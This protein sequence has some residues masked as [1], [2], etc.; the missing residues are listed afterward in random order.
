MKRR[1]RSTNLAY[2]LLD[3][4]QCRPNVREQTLPVM[5]QRQLPRQAV[6]QFAI[7]MPLEVTY[8]L[9]DRALRE[10][11][12]GGGTGKTAMARRGFEGPQPGDQ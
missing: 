1:P 7:Q 11:K 2:C 10:V 4:V 9:A 5:R 12:I 8:L 6:E 3:A